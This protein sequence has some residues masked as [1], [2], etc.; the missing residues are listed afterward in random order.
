[1]LVNLV[2][3][4]EQVETFMQ[5][6]KEKVTPPEFKGMGILGKAD[7]R[8]L[9]T[10]VGTTTNCFISEDTMSLMTKLKESLEKDVYQHIFSAIPETAEE[11]PAAEK[12]RLEKAIDGEDVFDL[13]M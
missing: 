8:E 4:K 10:F 6:K 7:G 9:G 1:M 12:T 2:W 13:G 5:N 3:L 11:K